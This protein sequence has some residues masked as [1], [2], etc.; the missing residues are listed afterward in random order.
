MSKLFLFTFWVIDK[1]RIERCME[2][3]RFTFDGAFAAGQDTMHVYTSCVSPVVRAAL[4]ALSI[5]SAKKH[6][7][8][9]EAVSAPA[10]AGAR[11]SGGTV[12]AYGQTGSG[13]TFTIRAIMEKLVEDVFQS[14]PS[15]NAPGLRSL[16]PQF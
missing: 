3:H 6:A 10:D 8:A 9:H 16:F 5:A 4:S 7:A 12:F 1:C 14:A 13:K 15:C 2:Q 11:R